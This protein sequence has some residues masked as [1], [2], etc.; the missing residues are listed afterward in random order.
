MKYSI[1]KQERYT[2]FKLE[3][4][5]LNTLIAPK[6]KSEF[7]IMQNEG[8]KNLIMDMA[9]VR[10]VDS[11]GLSALLIAN[12]IWK[13]TGSYV[14]TGVQN[15][16]VKKLIEISRLDSVLTVIPTIEESIEY[17]MMEELER[18]LNTEEE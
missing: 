5:S 18:E 15:S 13:V 2:I 14:L 11:S 1:D 8:I 10:F 12:R 3:E 4:E 16:N 17:V 9:N 7:V 6:L